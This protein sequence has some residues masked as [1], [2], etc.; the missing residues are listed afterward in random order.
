MSFLT[1]ASSDVR[2]EALLYQRPLKSQLR[3]DDWTGPPFHVCSYSM[4]AE[5]AY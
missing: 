4:A 1:S 2:G 3:G 5:V